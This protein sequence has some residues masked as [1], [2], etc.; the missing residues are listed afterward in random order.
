MA[1]IITL[2]QGDTRML[3]LLN[4][5]YL[6]LIP[7]K[8]DAV[9]AKD[10]RPISLV[11]SFA[12][13]VTKMM[14]NRL[15]PQLDSLVA[16]NQSAFIRGRCIHDNYM[17]VQQTI[18]ILH[19][20][21]ISSLFLKLDISKAFDS[22]DWAFLLEILSQLG[23]G[24]AW[25]NLVSN[26]LQSASTQVLLN[27]EPGVFI[28]H[29]RGLRQ[30]DPLSPMLFILV[31][32]VLNSLFLKAEA[33]DLLLPLHSTGQRLSLYADDVALFIRSE[34]EDLQ[35]TKELLQVFG[36]ASG[37]Q[38]N[39]QKSCVIPIHCDGEIMEVVNS[40]LQCTTTNFPTTYLGLPIS[41]R[42]LRRSDLMT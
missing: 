24:A 42:K 25:R 3:G 16:S 9:E 2:Q 35:I 27:G 6:T 33:E 30:G 20:R 11:H 41:D 14:A 4:S 31:M 1:A 5:A 39:L 29:R 8:A 26:L 7:K 36:E 12:K 23:F 37:L 22:V 38:T 40:I 13:L 15:A 10:Y 19:R 17:L 34:E 28:T 32:D 21:K 18:K